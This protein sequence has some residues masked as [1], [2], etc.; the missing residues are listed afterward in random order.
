MSQIDLA[1]VLVKEAVILDAGNV[2]SKQMVFA[3]LASQFKKAGVI[4]DTDEYIKSLEERESIGSTFM[5]NFI[6]L[7]HGRSETVIRPGIG[8]LRC[9]EPFRYQSFDEEGDVRYVFMLAVS[10]GEEGSNE[11]L[12]VLASLARLLAHREFIEKLEQVETYEELLAIV[13]TCQQEIAG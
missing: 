11:H 2:A 3:C 6:A 5:G 13:K 10:K 12:R 4:R 9:K 7:P 8:F 1:E